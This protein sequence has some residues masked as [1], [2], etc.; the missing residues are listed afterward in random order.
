ML[1]ASSATVGAMEGTEVTE[2]AGVE[3]GV[4]EGLGE[5]VGWRLVGLVTTVGEGVTLQADKN[6]ITSKNADNNPKVDFLFSTSKLLF[7]FQIIKIHRY[8]KASGH[9]WAQILYPNNS[10]W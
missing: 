6:I 7:K 3:T 5:V 2:G 8:G 4:F 1:V 9:K 10:L